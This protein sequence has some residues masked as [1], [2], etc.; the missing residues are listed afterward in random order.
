M[1]ES[2]VAV[3]SNSIKILH[4]VRRAEGGILAHVSALLGGLDSAFVQSVAASPEALISF[5]A[6]GADKLLPIDIGDR[7]GLRTL[8]QAV[9]IARSARRAG[10][11]I[12][13]AHGYKAAVPTVIAARMARVRSV[14]TGHNLF[15]ENASLPARISLRL[16]AAC[17]D[18]VIAVSGALGGSLIAAGVDQGKVAVVPCGIDTD[19]CAGGD[20]PAARRSIDI[21]TSEPMVLAVARLTGVKGIEFLIRAAGWIGEK[22]SDVRFVVAGDGP[23]RAELEHVAEGVAPGAF[24]FLG[25][26]EDVRDLVAA[27][28]VVAVPSLAEGY[29]LMAAEAMAAG[30]AV[31]ASRVGGLADNISDGVT[32]VLVAPGDPEAL[33]VAIMSLLDSPEKRAALGEAAREYAQRELGIEKMFRQTEEVYRCV[34]S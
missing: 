31:V 24:K 20:G 26:R 17:A 18:K 30:R 29:G 22:R 34:V 33:A 12:I 5:E 21:A 14:V 6:L 23:D 11:D 3:V 27:A 1:V 7:L 2:C 28:D 15:P 13:H 19:A 32:G 9:S 4:V 25:Y 10:V 8:F 16:V